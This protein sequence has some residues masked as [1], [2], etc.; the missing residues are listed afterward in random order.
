MNIGV[1]CSPDNWVFQ[2]LARVAGSEHHVMAIRFADLSVRMDSVRKTEFSS[3]RG[4]HCLDNLDALLIRP[5]PAGS[6]EQVV[7]RMN[8][9]HQLAD[10]H[11]V[12]VINPPKTIEAAVDKYLCLEQIRGGLINV[13]ATCVAETAETA[14]QQFEQLGQDTVVKPLFGSGG[15]GIQRV[16]NTQDA[17][18]LFQRKTETREIIYQQEYIE[19]GDTDLRLLVVGH[20]VFGMRRT[21]PGQWIT[22]IQQGAT[23]SQHVPTDQETNIARLAAARIGAFI[24]GVDLIYDPNGQ[25][26]VIEVNA[27]PGWRA[28]SDVSDSD[29]SKTIL[30]EIIL[31]TKAG[32]QRS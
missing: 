31:Q 4:S 6:L 10:Q 24:A 22:N 18:A 14:L 16:Q 5:M 17:K 19:H 32:Q 26:R 9:I 13:P 23:A 2:E 15:V 8:V 28:I 3:D 11:H 12:T 20:S 29:L 7:F 21:S 25:P 27:C 30:R 1:L